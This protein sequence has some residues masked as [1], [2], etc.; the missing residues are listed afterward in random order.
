MLD[1]RK[2]SSEELKQNYM[3]SGPEDAQLP[4]FAKELIR[5]CNDVYLHRTLNEKKKENEE[6]KKKTENEEKRLN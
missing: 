6:G 1:E 4:S 2:I 5:Y 3:I